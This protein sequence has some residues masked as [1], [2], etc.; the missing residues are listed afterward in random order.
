MYARDCDVVFG[1]QICILYHSLQRVS[2]SDQ[3][4]APAGLPSIRYFVWVYKLR[5]VN[6]N[7]G[8]YAGYVNR[9]SST[10]CKYINIL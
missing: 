1:I 8:L 3:S 9:T 5:R 6:N 2:A 10:Q 7:I 4:S